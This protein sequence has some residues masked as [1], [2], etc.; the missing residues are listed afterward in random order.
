MAEVQKQLQDSEIKCEKLEMQQIDIMESLEMMT[1][2]KE[3]AEEKSESLLQELEIAK[4][5][6]EELNLNLEVL[7]EESG[8]NIIMLIVNL[9]L[10]IFFNKLIKI[11]L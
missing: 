3:M 6:I 8:M 7:K 1:L 11:Y 2:D 10:V 5:K 9:L 4:E